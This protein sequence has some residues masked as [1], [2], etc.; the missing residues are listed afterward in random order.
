MTTNFRT[1]R[2]A[3]H[4][5]GAYYLRYIQ[6]IPEGHDPV[7]QLREQAA[8]VHALL[9]HLTDEQ[10]LLRYA[11]GK[12]SIKET[13]GHIID[14]ERVFAYRLLRIAR[15]DQ[16]ALPG[17]DQDQFTALSGADARPLTDIL[18]EYDA[19]RA[20]TLALL[21]SLPEEA[22]AR[23]GTASDMP[24]SVRALAYMLAGHE[25]HHLQLW[26]ERVM[27]LLQTS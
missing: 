9:G 10:A 5:Y 16:Q 14:T 13:L 15:G 19:V 18:R 24:V 17:F 22:F 11:P 7:Q 8:A 23:L 27:P 12:W 21:E 26:R 3:A 1:T 4:E 6:Q 25:A 20:A 2:P